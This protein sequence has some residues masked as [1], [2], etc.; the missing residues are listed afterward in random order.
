MQKMVDGS[1]TSVKPDRPHGALLINPWIHDFAAYDFWAKPLGTVMLSGIL[2]PRF[3][4]ELSGLPGSVPFRSPPLP[5]LRGMAAVLTQ[6]PDSEN[7]K[8]LCGYPPELTLT[9]NRAGKYGSER[10]WCAA[11]LLDGLADDL[12][13]P[14]VFRKPS[15]SPARCLRRRLSSWAASTRPRAVR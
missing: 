11:Y 12:L 2:T 5:C 1:A 7:G 4:R 9:R 3:P 10:T 13:V 14:W 6:D 15:G 8:S